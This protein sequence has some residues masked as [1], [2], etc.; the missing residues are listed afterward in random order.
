MVRLR[1]LIFIIVNAS[2]ESSRGWAKT[3]EG[4]SNTDLIKAISDTAVDSALRTKFDAF[5]L[6][7]REW[8]AAVRDWRCKLPKAGATRLGA[9]SDWACA[10]I[11]FEIAE[12]AFDQ[13]DPALASK[14]AAIPSRF[15]LSTEQVTSLIAAGAE[16][17][18]AHAVI[19][20]L[21]TK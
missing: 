16:A 1:R 12:I 2:G 13:L 19:R 17:L 10:N 6:T 18:A 9:P 15:Q 11:K 4:P 20:S 14:L 7:V 5:R 8:E 21:V 3:L